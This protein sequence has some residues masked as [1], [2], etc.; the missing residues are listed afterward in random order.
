MIDFS[1]TYQLHLKQ[2]QKQMEVCADVCQQMAGGEKLIIGVM[3]KSSGGRKPE[4]DGRPL[5][6]VKTY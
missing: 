6:T 5:T 1:H 2:F 4:S 3:V